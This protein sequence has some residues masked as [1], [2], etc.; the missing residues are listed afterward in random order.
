[1]FE[2]LVFCID[3]KLCSGHEEAAY[4]CTYLLTLITFF[5]RGRNLGDI[6]YFHLSKHTFSYE[7]FN[8]KF[9]TFDRIS[10]ITPTS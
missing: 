6:F 8:K 1:M 4:R 3:Y 2:V 9:T 5:A 7:T 10:L